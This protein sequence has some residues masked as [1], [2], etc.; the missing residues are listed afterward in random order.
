[1][2]AAAIGGPELLL[3]TEA[4]AEFAQVHSFGDDLAARNRNAFGVGF[5]IVSDHYPALGPERVRAQR[6]GRLAGLSPTRAA[7]S[8]T[9]TTAA[10]SPSRAERHR[11]TPGRSARSTR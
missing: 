4:A 2:Y 7:A 10:G 1:M 6:R 9:A 8:R 3:R 11:R 5:A